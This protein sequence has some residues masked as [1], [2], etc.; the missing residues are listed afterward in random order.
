MPLQKLQFRPGIVR[1]ITSYSNEGGWR[2]GDRIRF[3]FG[4]P[5]SIRGWEKLSAKTF[6]GTC[7]ALW[8]WVS[9]SG[10]RYLGVGTH[11]KYYIEEG[12]AYYDIT[13]LRLTTS[14]GDVTFTAAADALASDVNAADETITLSDAS[15][16]P[17]TGL[18]QINNEQIRYAQV[19]GN[20]LEGLT[21]GVNGTTVASHS[22]SDAVTCATLLVSHTSHGAR[23]N[24][25]VTYSGS[26][27]L[28]DEITAAVLNQEYQILLVIDSDSYL[29]EARAEAALSDITASDG[30]EPTPVFATSSDTGD[31]G[32]SVVGAY[33]LNTGLDTTIV[34][35]GWGAGTWSR[36]AWG[37]AATSLTSGD[38]LRIWSHDNFGEDLL[39]N[40][41]DD[42]VYYWDRTDGTSTRAVALSDLSGAVAAPTIAKMVLVSDRD[43]HVIAFGCDPETDPGTQDPLLIRFSNQESVR[44]WN[45]EVTNTAGDLRLGSGS[46]IITA[47]ETRQQVLVFTD[48]ALYAM[49]YLGPPFTFGATLISENITTQGPMCA[50]AVGD[51]VYWMGDGCFYAYQGTVQ[52]MPCPVKSYVFDD[53][54]V[55]QNE[56]VTAS[57]NSE[58]GE[59]WWFYPS[60][61]SQE[62]NRYVVYNYQEQVWYYG[63][64]ARTAWVDRG[65]LG[66]PIAAAPDHYLYR[67][68]IGFNDGSVEP[69]APLNSYLVSS[70]LD[71]GDGEQFTMVRRMFPDVAFRDS[72]SDAPAVTITTR[73]RN[74]PGGSFLRLV[75]SEVRDSTEQVNLRLRGRQFSL[76]LDCSETDVSWRLGSMRYDIQPDGRR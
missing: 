48:T 39:I 25:F 31:G 27:T 64:M 1:E 14:A 40:V 2:D 3:R 32:A 10:D 52:Q 29:I 28:G 59:I 54:N 43:R 8:P 5:E 21:R 26:T 61:D 17:D 67:H 72:A 6:L 34:G 20:V 46:E 11:L 4:Y 7:R 66:N 35:T 63:T 58:D 53:F 19:A 71:I 75:Q 68:E 15:G 45:A 50:V 41:R 13:P 73:S 69:A 18:I 24:D 55:L 36:G 56:K 51:A 38:R 12:G 74:Y 22:T 16:F 23:E 33:Q 42:G 44:E 60:A 30:L 9:L 65:I 49:Q 37:S 47:V 57:L 62:N 70:P 76:R